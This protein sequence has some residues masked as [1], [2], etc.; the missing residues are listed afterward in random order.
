MQGSGC[1][2]LLVERRKY[3]GRIVAAPASCGRLKY[4][5]K[6]CSIRSSITRMGLSSRSVDSGT[7]VPKK[8]GNLF[9][10]VQAPVSYLSTPMLLHSVGQQF[11]RWLRFSDQAR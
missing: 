4:P 8:L 2:H 9:A 3:S 11:N 10:S 7:A 6:S 1:K 5:F